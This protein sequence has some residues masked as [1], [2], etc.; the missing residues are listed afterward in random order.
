MRRVA[1][2]VRT[3]RAAG[4]FPVVLSGNCNSAVQPSVV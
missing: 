4:Q 2:A 1:V 3:V